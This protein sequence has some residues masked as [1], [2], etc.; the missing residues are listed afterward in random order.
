MK[1]AIAN[2]DVTIFNKL[3]SYMAQLWT[4]AAVVNDCVI[5]DNK[6]AIPEPLRK[7]VLARL[8]RSHTGQEAVMSASDYIWWPFLNQQIVD[9]CEKCRECTLYGKHLK[10][11]KTFHTAQ[12]LPSLSGPNQDLLLDIGGPIL[13][14]EGSKIFLLVAVDRFSKF[15][16][17]L[18]TK[19][20]G[21]K[22][23][24]KFLASY[25]HKYG[26]PQSVRIDNGS[27]FK[28]D[29]VQQFCSSKGIKHNLSPVGVT[30]AVVWLIVQYKI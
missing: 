9:T 21:G 26:V 24:K 5:V 11:A 20:T 2:K 28:N 7:A 13:D 14:D 10:T 4:K 17:V 22:K 23:V 19:T 8:H 27:G 6:L 18:I 3:G 29:L 12:F 25:K 30:E 16:S 15:P 1:S